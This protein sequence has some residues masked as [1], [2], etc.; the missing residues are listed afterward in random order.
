MVAY[1]LVQ[2]MADINHMLYTSRGIG[3]AG[4]LVQ[5]IVLWQLLAWQI[6]PL[7]GL[8][9]GIDGWS[10]ELGLRFEPRSGDETGKLVRLQ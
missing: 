2:A 5:A 3:L 1:P 7:S 9:A 10:G 8:A 4:L 6:R